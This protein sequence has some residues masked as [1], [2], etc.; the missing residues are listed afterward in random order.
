MERLDNGTSFDGNDIDHTIHIG[1]FVGANNLMDET[2]LYRVNVHTGATNTTTNLIQGS[3]Y[4]DTNTT[5]DATFTLEPQKAGREIASDLKNVA[6]EGRVIFH[7]IKLE[8]S[9][10]DEAIGFQPLAISV[11]TKD[12]A[13]RQKKR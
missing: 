6:S 12:K 13:T 9:T 11:T 10:N 8:M 7:S 3:Y 1:S 5:P 4:K 2:I